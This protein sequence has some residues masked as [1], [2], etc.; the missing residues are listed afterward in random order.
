MDSQA[1]PADPLSTEESTASPSVPDDDDISGATARNVF[2]FSLPLMVVA[3]L[4]LPFV[5]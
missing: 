1:S 3:F 5:R 2:G 4:P